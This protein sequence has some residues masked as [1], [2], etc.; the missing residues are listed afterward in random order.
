MRIIANGDMGVGANNPDARLD[1]SMNRNN[2]PAIYSHIT[3]NNSNWSG[4]EFY[5]PNTSGGIGVAGI[6]FYGVNGAATDYWGWAGYFEGDVGVTGMY[7]GSDERWKKN[8]V[9]LKEENGILRKVMLLKPKSYNWR[10]EEFPGMGFNPN[11]TSF[12][13]IAQD[14]KEIFPELV[15]SKNI[16]DPKVKRGSNE[17]ITSASGYYMVDYTGLIPILT[18]ALQEQ[19]TIINAQEMRI[20]KL[21]KVVGELINKN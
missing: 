1:V 13:F 8:I 12:G 19:Q 18:E 9:S 17:I 16:P 7:Y 20:S 6:G 10:A 15:I 2:A 3:V 4:G 5:N 21:E 11:R 14:L